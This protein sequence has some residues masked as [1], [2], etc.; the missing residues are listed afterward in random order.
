MTRVNRINDPQ[1]EL[2]ATLPR[3]WWLVGAGV[4]VGIVLLEASAGGVLSA[5]E[6]RRF[7]LSGALRFGLIRWGYWGLV[8]PLLYRDAA[9]ASEPGRG[10]RR[11]ALYLL[12]RAFAH[13]CGRAT[14]WALVINLMG[15]VDKGEP[16]LITFRNVFTGGWPGGMIAYTA[17]VG[18]LTA[19]CSTNRASKRALRE[20]ALRTQAAQAELRAL[21]MQ[22]HPHFLFNALH[23]ISVLIGKNE[24]AA[25]RVVLLLGDLLRQSLSR[26]A[27]QEVTLQE[28]IDFLRSYLEIEETR[29]PDRLRVTIEVPAEHLRARVPSFILQPLVE[30]AIRYGIAPRTEAGRVVVRGRR[31]G[32]V[33]LLE[34]WNDGP[35]ATLPTREG[36]GLRT[37]RE[38]L[39]LL[40]GD[41]GRLALCNED[42][43]VTAR[44]EIPWREEH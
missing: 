2:P 6:G 30:N 34:V 11:L 12:P 22:L 39:A 13:A 37:T 3:K 14:V 40:F 27:I 38:R 31:T 36:I 24:D 20:A 44:V 25:R 1:Q 15:S 4:V 26:N 8:L 18:G 35:A 9:W 33:L 16:L 7:P 43:G 28:E 10:G 32:D 29:F 19:L 23:A 5:I 41:A 42:G 17:I 21:H